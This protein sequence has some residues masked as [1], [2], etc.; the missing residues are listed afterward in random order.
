[1]TRTVSPRTDI[2]DQDLQDAAR[3]L[4]PAL[5]N[6]GIEIKAR[7]KILLDQV[8]TQYLKISNPLNPNSTQK[9]TIS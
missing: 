8:T 5:D 4:M 9:I 1:M 2:T 7:V 6:L 3:M